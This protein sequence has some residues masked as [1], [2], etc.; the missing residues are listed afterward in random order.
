MTHPN[1]LE[2]EQRRARERQA[3][4]QA[5]PGERVGDRSLSTD[6]NLDAGRTNERLAVKAGVGS[7]TIQRAIK[8]RKQGAPEVQKAV[9]SGGGS[10][11]E[12]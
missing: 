4:T 5:K 10:S 7:A 8:V 2:F 11:N 12:R 9:E 1:I 6:H 3:A